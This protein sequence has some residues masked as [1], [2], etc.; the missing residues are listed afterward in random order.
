MAFTRSFQG[1]GPPPSYDKAPFTKA[2]LEESA[3]ED[4]EWALLQEFTLE[5]VDADPANP[6]PRDFTT[7]LAA[8]DPGYYRFTWVKADA[9]VFVGDAVLFPA[10]PEW[11]PAV[12]DVGALI[13]AR[14]K[15][16]GSGGEELGTFN[17][18]TRPTGSEVERLIEKAVRRVR[19]AISGEPCTQELRQNAAGAAALYAAMLVEQSYF[20][21]STAGGSFAALQALWKEQISDLK[22]AVDELCGGQGPGGEGAGS[23]G[24]A[25]VWYGDDRPL[26]GPLTPEAW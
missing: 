17:D 8:L 3:A 7:D 14:T 9:S 5:P 13:R 24:S 12:A 23:G 16:M 22:S 1:Y 19:T 11:T 4:G 2:R 15:A 10:A 21:E 18:Q 26:I 25:P 20:P 6:A